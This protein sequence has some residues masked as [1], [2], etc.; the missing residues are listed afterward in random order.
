M[1]AKLIHATQRQ[2]LWIC[3]WKPFL[4]LQ[5][6]SPT[7]V[8]QFS[9][10]NKIPKWPRNAQHLLGSAHSNILQTLNL[11]QN[12]TEPIKYQSENKKSHGFFFMPYSDFYIFAVKWILQLSIYYLLNAKAFLWAARQT[13]TATHPVQPRA[14]LTKQ[15]APTFIWG[16]HLLKPPFSLQSLLQLLLLLYKSGW[17]AAWWKGTLVYWWTVGWIGASSVPRW[18]R[19]PMASWL[20]SGTVW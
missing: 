18:P 3:P 17:K 1:E 14:H 13:L 20:V 16:F 4:S 5:E 12:A 2:L 19:R 11:N 7:L 10:S 15:T 6:G 9:Y 8:Q